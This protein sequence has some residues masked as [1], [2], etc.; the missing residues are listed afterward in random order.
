VEFRVKILVNLE[1]VSTGNP[2]LSEQ[3]V[4]TVLSGKCYLLC[5]VIYTSF[6][7]KMNPTR[8]KN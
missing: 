6:K 4:C 8:P 5:Q 7:L 3:I 2:T 1:T